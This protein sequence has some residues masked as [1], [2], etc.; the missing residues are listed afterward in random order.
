MVLRIT[1]L[2]LIFVLL[3]SCERIPDWERTS[4]SSV[5]KSQ[6]Q[7]LERLR[8]W[9]WTCRGKI[10]DVTS[11][12]SKVLIS[13]K[14]NSFLEQFRSFGLSSID[15]TGPKALMGTA[16]LW[17]DQGHLVTLLH[18]VNPIG[19]IECS[20]GD[21]P[22]LAA[23]T[24]GVDRP[25]N[26]AVLKVDL[27]D[28]K[29]NFEQNHWAR[30]SADV[31]G[32]ARFSIVASSYPRILDRLEVT[33]QPF[34]PSLNTGVDEGLIL[35]LPVPPR[36]L[37]GGVLIDEEVRV[38]GYLFQSELDAW[39]AA[40]SIEHLEGLVNAMLKNGTVDRPYSGF[41]A[42]FMAEKGFVIQQ[43]DVEGPAYQSGLRIKDRLMVWD[44][45][46]LDRMADWKDAGLEDIGRSIALTY[47]RGSKTVETQITIGTVQ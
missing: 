47:R 13:R 35:F 39:G 11:D 20:N 16:L 38:A 31:G 37:Q 25:L 6:R 10:K 4:V 2:I 15:Q 33:L 45:H 36:I 29:G 26:L 17:D 22:W 40:L 43:I 41:R 24:I 1:P 34:R 14:V 42:K 46:A 19:G 18:W 12:D 5:V 9:L 27:T 21:I 28:H 7:K 32:H 3:S 23:T 44:G 8:Y 30:R